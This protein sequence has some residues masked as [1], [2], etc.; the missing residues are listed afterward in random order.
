MEDRL[1]AFHFRRMD[2]ATPATADGQVEVLTPPTSV[3]RPGQWIQPDLAPDGVRLKNRAADEDAAVHHG[4]DGRFQ[5]SGDGARPIR[6][7]SRYG[8]RS[9]STV[10]LARSTGWGCGPRSNRS[11]TEHGILLGPAWRRDC[12]IA[13]GDEV[14]GSPR[15]RRAAA[16]RS[17]PRLR[18]RPRGRA[19]GGCV[20]RSLA[21]FY[22]KAYLRWIDS[23]KSSP[24]MRAA[25]IAE[26]VE[27]LKAGVKQRTLKVRRRKSTRIDE[28]GS[29]PSGPCP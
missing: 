10:S 25:R 29:I 27:L 28:L 14:R 12:G 26:T 19:R 1:L 20:L 7:R 24:E 21:Q 23:T 2:R 6:P 8:A 17:G 3:A 5:R 4:G 11:A 22:R 16:G 15:P 18:S 9:R 13:A